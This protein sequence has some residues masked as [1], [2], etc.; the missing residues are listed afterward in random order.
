[1]KI[2]QFNSQKIVTLTLF[3]LGTA[4]A[5]PAWSGDLRLDMGV[6]SLNTPSH[7]F[8]AERGEVSPFTR[9]SNLATYDGNTL[10]ASINGVMSFGLPDSRIFGA[11]RLDIGLFGASTSGSGSALFTD[12]G[13]GTRYGFVALDNS[14]GYGTSAVGDTLATSTSRSGSVSGVS[15]LLNQIGAG[16]DSSGFSFG[17]GAQLFALDQRTTS[18]GTIKIFSGPLTGRYDLTESLNSRFAGPEVN[19]AYRGPMSG[20]WRLEAKLAFAALVSDTQYQ[21]NAEHFT[22]NISD[23][24]TANAVS[25]S[26]TALLSSAQVSLSRSVGKNGTLRASAGIS[27]LSGAATINYGS[28]PSDPGGGVLRIE[29]GT[30]I[31]AQLGL[32]LGFAF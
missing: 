12:P 13:V 8:Y 27:Q 15:L 30:A 14:T 17:F 20:D 24:V 28:V 6:M 16:A 26:S 21:G 23:A 25:D 10:G 19:L 22:N 7:D 31:S 5:T 2:C 32:S 29:Y 18:S 11:Q 9:N 4:L 3:G 1:M